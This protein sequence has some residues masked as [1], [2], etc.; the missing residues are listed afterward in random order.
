MTPLEDEEAAT[1][2]ICG[3]WPIKPIAITL[4][5]EQVNLCAECASHCHVGHWR[6]R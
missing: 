5:D 2:E 6:A 4:E 1:C 3:A